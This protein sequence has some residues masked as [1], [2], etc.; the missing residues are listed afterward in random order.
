MRCWRSMYILPVALAMGGLSACSRDADAGTVAGTEPIDCRASGAPAMARDCTMERMATPDG[1]A[2]TVRNLADSFG[3]LG[4]QLD[5][6]FAKLVA[7][8]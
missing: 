2:L 3:V 5:N 1:V 7:L 6:D 8:S 4:Q